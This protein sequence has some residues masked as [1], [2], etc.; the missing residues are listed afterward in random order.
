MYLCK[1]QLC[2]IFAFISMCDLE[3]TEM[4]KKPKKKYSVL[5]IQS[6]PLETRLKVFKS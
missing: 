5:K 6:K 3:F 4:Y 1:F 2:R